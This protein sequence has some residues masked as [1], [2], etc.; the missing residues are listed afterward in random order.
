MGV[1]Y[2]E[3]TWS[4][5]PDYTIMGLVREGNYS[6]TCNVYSEHN[7]KHWLA[8]QVARLLR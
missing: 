8:L 7:V 4:S 1:V 2:R 3:L 5:W 6:H